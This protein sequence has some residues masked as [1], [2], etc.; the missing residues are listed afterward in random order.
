MF[1]QIKIQMYLEGVIIKPY[2]LLSG[3]TIMSIKL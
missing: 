3:F 2:E 1:T